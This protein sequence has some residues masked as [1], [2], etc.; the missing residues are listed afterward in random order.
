MLSAK[1]IILIIP[2]AATMSATVSVLASMAR[3]HTHAPQIHIDAGDDEELRVMTNLLMQRGIKVTV[4][5]QGPDNYDT[6]PTA[7]ITA[8]EWNQAAVGPTPGLGITAAEAAGAE[9]EPSTSG[10]VP[11]DAPAPE[12]EESTDDEQPED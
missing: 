8:E 3:S 2:E 4:P 10:E 12:V 7:S 1:R 6:D 9:Q 5:K 11:A